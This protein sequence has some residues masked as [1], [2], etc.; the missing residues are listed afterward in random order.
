M[1]T[2]SSSGVVLF[3]KAY[4]VTGVQVANNH[5]RFLLNIPAGQHPLSAD[6]TLSL[7]AGVWS[8]SVMV[9]RQLAISGD[10]NVS[11]VDFSMVALAYGSSPGTSR[12][13]PAADL[14][15][16]GTI[17]IVDVSMVALF[18]GAKAFY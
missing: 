3:S 2:N 18:Y 14:T 7:N 1:A 4:T 11:I 12:Y 5:A 13:N 6:V 15:G 9:S 16:N 10:G 17:S 8:A